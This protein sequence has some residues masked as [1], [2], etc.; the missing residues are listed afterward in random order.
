MGDTNK[1]FT[2]RHPKTNKWALKYCCERCYHP[3]KKSRMRFKDLASRNAKAFKITY[4]ENSEGLEVKHVCA[5]YDKV[6]LQRNDGSIIHMIP[7][8]ELR[9]SV[10]LSYNAHTCLTS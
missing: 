2:I 10:T 3:S 6:T 9:C 8:K 5:L 4:K 7:Q 1:K